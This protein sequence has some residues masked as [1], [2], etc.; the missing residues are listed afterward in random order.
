MTTASAF[1][2][3]VRRV[4]NVVIQTG[5]VKNTGHFLPILTLPKEVLP[6]VSQGAKH[7][8]QR[9][10]IDA[11]DMHGVRTSSLIP[12]LPRTQA[13]KEKIAI[14]TTTY[15]TARRRSP[16]TAQKTLLITPASGCLVLLVVPTLSSLKAEMMEANAPPLSIQVL[17]DV[18]LLLHLHNFVRNESVYLV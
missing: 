15:Q 14:Y 5:V 12:V 9:I 13:Y 17:R 1:V 11:K 8:A 16:M 3:W 2:P 10:Q 7:L 6:V 4:V 18:K